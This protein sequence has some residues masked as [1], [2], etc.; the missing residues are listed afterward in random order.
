MTPSP[1]S[2][3]R[4]GKMDTCIIPRLSKTNPLPSLNV[5]MNAI[6]QRLFIEHLHVTG[7]GFHILAVHLKLEHALESPGEILKHK[8]LNLTLRA[9]NS[10]GQG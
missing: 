10:V 1:H 8:F 6:I 5:N 3:L 7:P 4:L 2:L 9:T